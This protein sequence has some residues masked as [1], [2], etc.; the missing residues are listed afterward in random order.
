MVRA[1]ATANLIGRGTGRTPSYR[2]GVADHRNWI[3]ANQSP[4]FQRKVAAAMA[5]VTPI[6]MASDRRSLL[7]ANQTR[8][9][10]GVTFV[11]R[12]NDHAAGPAKPDH[13]GRSDEEVDITH[14]ELHRHGIQRRQSERP[15]ARHIEQRGETED[16]PPGNE[17]RPWQGMGGQHNQDERRGIA[18]RVHGV[19]VP[20]RAGVGVGWINRPVGDGIE[21]VSARVRQ[22]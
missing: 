16:R 21:S 11:S 15:A 8:P 1:A 17:H 10:P 2:G 20:Y 14:R 19:Q 13:H 12:T 5:A 9:T 7:T 3:Q 4:G 18:D 22:E 6:A